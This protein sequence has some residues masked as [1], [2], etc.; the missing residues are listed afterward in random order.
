MKTSYTINGDR[1]R[2]A[3]EIKG[4]TQAELSERAGVSQSAIAQ[5]EQ[6]G[7]MPT[8]EPSETLIQ[9]IA[10]QLGF[11]VSFF[12]K[13]SGPELPLGS[14]LYRKK[15]ALK[16]QERNRLR[17]LARL[18]YEMAQRMSQR[19]RLPSINLPIITDHD[20]IVAAR[21][22]RSSLG[23][24]PDT[25][26]KNLIH[27]LEKNGVLVIAVPYEIDEHDSFST[28]V[29]DRTP[30]KPL[31]VISAGKPGD[32]Q[33]WSVAHELGHLVMHRAWQGELKK[34]EDEANLFAGEFLLPA[35]VIREEIHAPVTLSQL[36]A[37]KPK[38]G[39]SIQALIRRALDLEIITYRQYTY[40]MTQITT[41]GW[42]KREPQNLDI[43]AEKPRALRK[44]AELTYGIPIDYQKMANEIAAPISLVEVVLGAHAEQ[45]ELTMPSRKNSPDNQP[46]SMPTINNVIP[47]RR[48]QK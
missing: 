36:A 19:L 34:M 35:E 11:P 48:K 16:S 25:P 28:W 26:V 31:V 44:M 10:L 38:W 21:V 3:R 33:R 15:S 17:Q 37:L 24:S 20:P 30:F 46:Q 41:L 29:A 7:A 6:K 4:L 8:F 14:L 18:A 23:L 27:Q 32:R 5:L 42:R 9:S 47:L 39:V 40:L 13:E 1:I 43:A 45:R 12:R 22:T 2:Q